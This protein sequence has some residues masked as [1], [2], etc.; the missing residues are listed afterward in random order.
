MGADGDGGVGSVVFEGAVKTR[1]LKKTIKAF[2][3][4]NE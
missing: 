4:P 2:L 3:V 1:G